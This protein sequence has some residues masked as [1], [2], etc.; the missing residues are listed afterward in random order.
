MDGYTVERI[1]CDHYKALRLKNRVLRRKK[2]PLRAGIYLVKKDEITT[3]MVVM[4]FHPRLLKPC[5]AE[6]SVPVL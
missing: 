1:G 3:K 6:G 5:P 2:D 4:D